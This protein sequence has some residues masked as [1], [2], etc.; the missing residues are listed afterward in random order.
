[1]LG[2]GFDS[3]MQSSWAPHHVQMRVRRP[4]PHDVRAGISMRVWQAGGLWVKRPHNHPMWSDRD[5]RTGFVVRIGIAT[6][7]STREHVS[8]SRNGVG[9]L[10]FVSCKISGPLHRWSVGAHRRI[11]DYIR[12][13]W[14]AG[15]AVRTFTQDY[16]M[17]L[18][19]F[20]DD[21]R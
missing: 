5:R 9:W 2:G 18:R 14:H 10:G 12:I 4:R 11:P 7:S 8:D 3:P 17:S 15:K 13:A 6:L 19:I 1:M 21:C 20:V 16:Y